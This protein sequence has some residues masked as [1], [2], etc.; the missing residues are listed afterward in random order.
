L[1]G[2]ARQSPT[3]DVLNRIVRALGVTLAELFRP[4][5]HPYRVRFR[6]RRV[7]FSNQNR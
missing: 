5:D 4:L 3:L 6:K 2:Y 7:D 1:I